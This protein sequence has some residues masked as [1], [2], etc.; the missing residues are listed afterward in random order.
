MML[1]AFAIAAGALLVLY[2]L[3][4][5]RGRPSARPRPLSWIAVSTSLL[6]LAGCSSPSVTTP[7]PM[8][9]ISS[10][11]TP[12]TTTAATQ[13]TTAPKPGDWTMYHNDNARTG[14]IQNFPDPKQLSNLWNNPLDG[15]VY[16][17]P[18]VVNGHLLVATEHD[19]IYSFDAQTGKELWHTNVGTPVSQ[20]TLPCGNIDPLGI[21]GTPVYDPATNEL[22]AVAEVT[23]PSHVLVGIDVDN[24]QV[25]L[26]R[27]IDT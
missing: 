24:G 21:T 1:F 17:E 26:R 16:A 4:T 27:Q 14:Y 13:V 19:N 2:R 7:P 15:A 22:F 3:A 9:P 10:P 12:A 23:G 6:V 25:K 8:T 11:A 18:L 20:S 5:A